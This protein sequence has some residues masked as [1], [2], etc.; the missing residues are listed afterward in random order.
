MMGARDYC[1]DVVGLEIGNNF[2]TFVNLHGG[3]LA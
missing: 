2:Q 1:R 3:T